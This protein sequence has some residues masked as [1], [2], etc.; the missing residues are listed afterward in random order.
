V[1]LETQKSP[2]AGSAEQSAQASAAELRR[3]EAQISD[4][5]RTVR[6]QERQI[7]KLQEAVAGW[8]KKYEFLATESPSAY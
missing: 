2:A 5:S 7:A 3:K 8:R 1:E 6:E 4:L